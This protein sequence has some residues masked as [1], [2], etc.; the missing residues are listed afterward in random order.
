MLSGGLEVAK[1]EGSNVRTVSGISGQ[2]KN[3]LT[4]PVVAFRATLEDKVLSKAVS[5]FFLSP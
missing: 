4:K 2:I 1:F 5:N 3:A